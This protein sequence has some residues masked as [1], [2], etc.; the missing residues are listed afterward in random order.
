MACLNTHQPVFGAKEMGLV[1]CLLYPKHIYLGNRA[2]AMAIE[3]LTNQ[4]PHHL[5]RFGSA[6]NVECLMALPN[7][8]IEAPQVLQDCVTKIWK[9]LNGQEGQGGVTISVVSVKNERREMAKLF[10]STAEDDS[11]DLALGASGELFSGDARPRSS[12]YAPFEKSSAMYA[13]L[14]IEGKDFTL[15]DRIGYRAWNLCETI[16]KRQEAIVR[17]KEEAERQRQESRAATKAAEQAES[18]NPY[19]RVVSSSNSARKRSSAP[20]NVAVS[21]GAANPSKKRSS[22]PPPDPGSYNKRTRLD[23]SSASKTPK[24]NDTSANKKCQLQILEAMTAAVKAGTPLTDIRAKG[25]WEVGPSLHL[26]TSSSPKDPLDM[27]QGLFFTPDEEVAE[28]TVLLLFGAGG[29]VAP[30]SMMPACGEEC[31]GS[32]GNKKKAN[33]NLHWGCSKCHNRMVIQPVLE[34]GKKGVTYAIDGD[35]AKCISLKANHNSENPNMASGYLQMPLGIPI[36][37]LYTL[38]RLLAGVK[39]ELTY[40]YC[41]VAA[42]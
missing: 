9:D 39:V 35:P 20:P 33:S 8:G 4:T 40:D 1:E 6:A 24:R 26:A 25:K 13:V 19:Q 29:F 2:L 36:P 16:R 42:K 30:D 28:H 14:M 34:G 5:I 37:F 31:N 7:P 27:A 11:M 18:T 10:K 22:A 3:E 32:D 17:K 41:L 12:N 21:T 15:I 38:C 23:E